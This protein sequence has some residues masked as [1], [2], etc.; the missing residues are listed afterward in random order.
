MFDVVQNLDRN[1]EKLSR[2]WPQ[3]GVLLT[4]LY[5]G[6]EGRLHVVRFAQGIGHD[7]QIVG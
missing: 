5:E 6:E 7:C 3:D 4:H 1:S 2:R